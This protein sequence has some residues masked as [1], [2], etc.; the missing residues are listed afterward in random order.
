VSESPIPVVR[1]FFERANMGG[2]DGVLELLAPDAVLVVPPEGSAEPDTYRG[3][4]G[5]RR[6][7]GGFEGALE[8]LRFEVLEVEQMSDDTVL[9]ET[10]F[11]GRGTTTGIEVEQVTFA[12]ITVR[13]G[14][15]ASIMPFSERESALAA[16]RDGAEL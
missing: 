6:Y 3:H 12:A 1:S 10:R 14:L 8:E 4:D 2:I 13:D 7:F 5:A 16:A 11:R 15:V 9:A